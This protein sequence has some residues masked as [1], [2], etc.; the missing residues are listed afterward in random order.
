MIS[1]NLLGPGT[2]AYRPAYSEPDGTVMY[3]TRSTHRTLANGAPLGGVS[4]PRDLMPPDPA[5]GGEIGQGSQLG[6]S[7]GFGYYRRIAAF[8]GRVI[9]RPTM[10]ANPAVGPVGRSNRQA[11]LRARIEALYTDYTPGAQAVAREVIENGV[12]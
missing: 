4:L 9:T 2:S 3:R 12:Q 8:T 1:E 10:G 6:W 7:T 11:R 5:T